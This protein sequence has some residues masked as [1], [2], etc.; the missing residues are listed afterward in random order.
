MVYSFG[1][2]CLRWHLLLQGS[3]GSSLWLRESEWIQTCTFQTIYQDILYLL[4]TSAP[5]ILILYSFYLLILFVT[6]WVSYWQE[7]GTT[8]LKNAVK[9]CAEAINS[10]KGKLIVKEA[11]RVVSSSFQPSCF[12]SLLFAYFS[13]DFCASCSVQFLMKFFGFSYFQL[14]LSLKQTSMRSFFLLYLKLLSSL[15][16]A[17]SW[18]LSLLSLALYID[19]CAFAG[20]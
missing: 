18:H 13:A 11:P 14:V 20:E 6:L 4:A 12:F 8:V 17:S 2:V 7:Q 19:T 3:L 5:L 16:R 9:A 10:H 1:Y 15:G